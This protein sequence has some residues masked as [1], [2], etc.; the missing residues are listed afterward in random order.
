MGGRVRH[1]FGL[2]RSHGKAAVIAGTAAMMLSTGIGF[3]ANMSPTPGPAAHVSQKTESRINKPRT[4][5]GRDAVLLGPGRMA[6][7]AQLV[8]ARSP[9]HQ[10]TTY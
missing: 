1:L 6:V 4:G 5:G 7:P 2:S 3:A 8:R 9:L 10:A